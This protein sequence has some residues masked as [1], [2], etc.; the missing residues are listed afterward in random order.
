MKFF[1]LLHFLFL[2]F[3]PFFFPF[4]LYLFLIP[5]HFLFLLFSVISFHPLSSS[6][7]LFF[8]FFFGFLSFL[9]SIYPFS[10]PYICLSLSLSFFPFPFISL[11]LPL[12][13]FLTFPSI[14]LFLF[15]LN[16]HH[17]LYSTKVLPLKKKKCQV[18][19]KTQYITHSERDV[20]RDQHFLSFFFFLFQ[21]IFILLA[22][23]SLGSA[24]AG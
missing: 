16:N 12:F 2:S 4:F 11:F 9:F 21:V 1:F 7:L 22:V 8:S 24:V 14:F 20:T 18:T 19:E 13:L 17:E 6:F 3:P 5:F 10:F 23:S 15:N